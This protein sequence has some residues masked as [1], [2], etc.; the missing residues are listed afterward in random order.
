MTKELPNISADDITEEVLNRFF[1]NDTFY[2]VNNRSTIPT[3]SKRSSQ[4]YNFALFNSINE[5]SRHTLACTCLG[6][7]G[8]VLYQKYKKDTIHDL[9]IDGYQYCAIAVFKHCE[10]ADKLLHKVI[11][12]W[13]IP[14]EVIDRGEFYILFGKAD[15]LF[16]T[17]WKVRGLLQL[18][19]IY[20]FIKESA[21]GTYALDEDKFKNYLN[22]TKEIVKNAP[23]PIYDYDLMLLSDYDIK[24]HDDIKCYDIDILKKIIKADTSISN[25]NFYDYCHHSMGPSVWAKYYLLPL[26]Q[27]SQNTHESE[28]KI[29]ASKSRRVTK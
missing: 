22:K 12:N 15:E 20:T 16:Y 23:S 7:I 13:H 3:I 26:M 19:R 25:T 24:D 29:K 6:F 18:Y 5:E 2:A 9:I 10:E 27:Q 17:S 4:V 11:R 14:I 21:L 28:N 8:D 1:K